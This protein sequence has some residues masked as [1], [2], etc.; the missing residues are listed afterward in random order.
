[1]GSERVFNFSAGPGTLPLP[2]LEAA[3]RGLYDYEGTGMGVMEMSHRSSAFEAILDAT[4]ADLRQVMGIPT[5]YKVLFLQGGASLQFAQIPMAFETPRYVVTGAWGEKAAEAAGAEPIWT[6]VANG[7]RSVPAFEDLEVGAGTIHLTTN[8]TIHGVEF[9]TD[10]PAGMRVIADASS[11][12]L[13]RPMDVSRYAMIYAGAQKNLGPAGVT[14]AILNDE[15]LSRHRNDV[16]AMLDYRVHAKNRSLYN[17]PPCWPIFVVGLVVKWVIQQGGVV[18]M[19]ARNATKSGAVYDAI[20]RSNGFYRPH[21][22]HRSRMNVVFTLP[23]KELSERFVSEA[24]G[25]G[26]DGLAGHRSIG[27]IRASLYNAMPVEGAMKL[28]EFM[29]EFARRH[30]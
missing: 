1:M 12:I 25:M 15:L 27:G 30:G 24:A 22:H 14:V 20:D 3:E 13:S 8:E 10:P 23:S 2:V 6:D 29:D 9:P 16:P 26:M 11:N 19:A 7:Y 17:T 5:D 21:A 4:E 28:A 18:G